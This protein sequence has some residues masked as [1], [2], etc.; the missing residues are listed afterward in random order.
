M[1]LTQSTAA[2]VVPAPVASELGKNDN[3]QDV[4]TENPVNE[5]VIEQSVEKVEEKEKEK[6]V[7]K[8]EITATPHSTPLMKSVES[9]K[10]IEVLERYVE[11][12]GTKVEVAPVDVAQSADVVKKNTK[13]KNK[14]KNKD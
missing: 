11:P 13:K 10:P 2:P 8:S 6:E 4:S 14:N 5:K 1:G 3:K 9:E 12:A 7:K